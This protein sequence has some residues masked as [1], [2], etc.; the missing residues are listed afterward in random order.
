M[1]AVREHPNLLKSD[2][3]HLDLYCRMFELDWRGDTSNK[4]KQEFM[5]SHPIYL[6]GT[7][8]RS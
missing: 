5:S 7:N 4:N 3:D 2:A 1:R 6:Q 8:L